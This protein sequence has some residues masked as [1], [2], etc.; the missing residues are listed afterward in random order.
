MNT[1]Y[2]NELKKIEFYGRFHPE[3]L[4]YVGDNYEKSKV[5]LLGESNYIDETNPGLTAE[6]LRLIDSSLWYTTASEYLPKDGCID[7]C[8]NRNIINDTL[9]KKKNGQKTSPAHN[10]YINPAKAF[11]EVFPQVANTW[12]AFSY[13]ASMNYFQ[14]PATKT[15]KSISQ[16]KEDEQFAAANL[17]HI[18]SVLKPETIIFLSKKAHWAFEAN[19]TAELKELYIDACAHPTCA[20]WNR[21]KGER[22][23]EKFKKIISERITI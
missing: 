21:D 22:G 20:W 16:K 15:G 19:E 1:S 4:P 6:V 17:C 7:W 13:F 14:K 5:L 12:D 9:E 10:M 3:Y 2:D 8:H 11:V 18:V 23:R